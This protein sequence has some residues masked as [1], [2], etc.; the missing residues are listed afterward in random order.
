MEISKIGGEG[1]DPECTSLPVERPEQT[2]FSTK[3][4]STRCAWEAFIPPPPL[5]RSLLKGAA[6]VEGDSRGQRGLFKWEDGYFQ[7][8]FYFLFRLFYVY[9]VFYL[10]VHLCMAGVRGGQKD[11]DSLDLELYIVVYRHVGTGN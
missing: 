10:H 5:H 8:A 3:D 4:S 6:Q 2:S 9:C 1:R 11:L 7:P